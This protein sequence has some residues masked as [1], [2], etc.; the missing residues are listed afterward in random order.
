ML[1]VKSNSPLTNLYKVE[2]IIPVLQVRKLRKVILIKIS[3]LFQLHRGRGRTEKSVFSTTCKSPSGLTIPPSSP[4]GPMSLRSKSINFAHKYHLPSLVKHLSASPFPSRC[5]AASHA[6]LFDV[7]LN[8]KQSEIAKG[9][10]NDKSSKLQFTSQISV[11][12]WMGLFFR[13]WLSE[14][15]K[16]STTPKLKR[17]RRGDYTKQ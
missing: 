2:Y 3:S 12:L 5:S 6:A 10:K 15:P 1:S 13:K 11:R 4:P 8:A 17:G 9:S 16:F 7:T 14:S